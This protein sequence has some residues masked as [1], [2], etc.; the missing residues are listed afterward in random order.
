MLKELYN[1]KYND[2]F[3]FFWT[4]ATPFS[5]FYKRA[6]SYKG[7]R[8]NYG[9]QAFMLEKALMFDPS[10]V[11]DIVKA[12][13]PQDVKRLGRA[14]QNFDDKVWKARRY[15]IMKE[16]LRAKFSDAGLRQLLLSTGNR[17]LVEASPYDRVW[18]IGLSAEDPKA[19]NPN[20][21]R[22]SNLLGK[23]LMEIRAEL[24]KN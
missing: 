2:N 23:A 14:V 6:F 21:W 8:L 16:V 1:M 4:G 18:G 20:N 12:N 11:E 7:Y 24:Q 15:E 5:N 9:E 3:V 10:K 19:L 13:N 17:T 22:G